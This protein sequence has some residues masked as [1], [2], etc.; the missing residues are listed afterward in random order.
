M[1]RLLGRPH[2]DAAEARGNKPWA[3]TAYLALAGGPVSATG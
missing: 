3:I 2:A 1:I